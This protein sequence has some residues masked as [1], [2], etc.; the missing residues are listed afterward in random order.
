ALQARLA[1]GGTLDFEQDLAGLWAK[2]NLPDVCDPVLAAAH[3]Q[4]L[5]TAARLWTRIDRAADAG[6]AGTIA[7]LAGWLPAAERA[8]LMMYRPMASW[9]WLRRLSRRVANTA[10]RDSAFASALCANTASPLA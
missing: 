1:D 3:D 5:L 10:C 9:P 7:N 4:G 2:P 8:M 6:Q